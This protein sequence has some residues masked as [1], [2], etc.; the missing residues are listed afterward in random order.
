MS[1]II[2]SVPHT[3]THF[4]KR[5]LGVPTAEHTWV[6][7][8]KLIERCDS[9]EHI[10]VP[11]RHPLK[12]R[13][14]WAGRGR[15]GNEEGVMR[16]WK[17]WFQLQALDELYGLDIIAVDR[18]TDPRIKNWAKERS[19]PRPLPDSWRK[20]PIE[21]VLELPVVNLFYKR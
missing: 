14:T 11:M 20:V 10:Y 3:G 21:P 6:S 7:W 18:Q 8:D 17:S 2:I 13:N 1:S 9:H 19:M 16:W 5:E 15:L 12:V 4:L